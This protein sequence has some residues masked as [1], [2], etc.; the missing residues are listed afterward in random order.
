M[1]EGDAKLLYWASKYLPYLGVGSS[2]GLGFGDLKRIS[3]ERAPF[4]TPVRKWTP[5]NRTSS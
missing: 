3:F 5:S 1:E 4:E 2:P